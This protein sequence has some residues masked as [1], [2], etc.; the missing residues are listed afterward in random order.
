MVNLTFFKLYI[1]L[2]LLFVVSNLKSQIIINEV[3]PINHKS[4]LDDDH[5]NEDWIE[6]YNP[7][8][9][10][11]NLKGYK[12][13]DRNDF[14]KA[15]VFPDTIMPPKSFLTLFASDKNRN[16]DDKLV[17]ETSGSGLY[18]WIYPEGYSFAY[19]EYEGDFEA[20]VRINTFQNADFWA[21]AGIMVREKL[22]NN[23]KFIAFV[24]REYL[25]QPDI[26]CKYRDTNSQRMKR[27]DLY[28]A[29]E[30]DYPDIFLHLIRKGN[31]FTMNYTDLSGIVIREQ[32][33]VLDLP[34]KIYLGLS[35]NSKNIE[36]TAKIYFSDYFI[37]NIKVDYNN[38]KFF[39]IN[40][41][42]KGK[43][44]SNNTLHT[45]FK[46]GDEESL[47]LFNDKNKLL[48]YVGLP[49]L[50]ADNTFSRN[51]NENISINSK[52]GYA[53]ATPNTKNSKLFLG[54]T[55]NPIFQYDK[56]IFEDKMSVKIK[57]I[58][59]SKI[60]FN[61][62]SDEPDT[63]S[64]IYNFTNLNI[65]KTTV[66]RARAFKDNYLP[67]DIITQ[68]FI[69]DYKSKLPVISLV[70]KND[71]LYNINYGILTNINSNNEI[72]G[73]LEFFENFDNI[74]NQNIGIKLHGG[75][76][77]TSDQKSLRLYARSVYNIDTINNLMFFKNG[78]ENKLIKNLDRVVLRSGGQDYYST[79]VR[80]IFAHQ[81]AKKLENLDYL[82]FNY[83]NLFLNG[84]YYGLTNIIERFDDNFIIQYYN[85]EDE[86]LNMMGEY[87]KTI[88]GNGL[89]YKTHYDSVMSYNSQDL[90]Y[91]NKVKRNFN[92]FNFLDYIFLNTFISTNDWSGQN[93][94]TWN[95]KNSPINFQQYDLDVSLQLYNYYHSMNMFYTMK[96][97]VNNTNQFNLFFKVMENDSIKNYFILHALDKI[98]TSFSTDSMLA[99]LNPIVD[100]IKDEIPAHQAKFPES[101]PNWSNAI[102]SIRFFL[103]ERPELYRLHLAEFFELPYDLKTVKINFKKVKINLNT[104]TLDKSF[105]GKYFINQ[106][107]TLEVDYPN[108][109]KFLYWLV[110][111]E[112]YSTNPKIEV[113]VTNN[114]DIIPVFETKTTQLL[115]A[116]NVF[117][118]PNPNNGNITLDINN[119]LSKNN[120]EN[121][122]ENLLIEVYDS[123]Q[124][125]IT[126][127]K[128]DYKSY[129]KDKFKLNLTEISNKLITGVYYLNVIVGNEIIYTNKFIIN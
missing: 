108:D 86:D 61:I 47:Y 66:F 75:I 111:N 2:F 127:I 116:Y 24:A 90:D 122:K 74:I 39:E 113:F 128:L 36:K 19:Q 17:M 37:N 46:I 121:T 69:K 53:N 25:F 42:D 115:N 112:I 41:G 52:W 100:L 120:K 81:L 11:V 110:N 98:N 23:S 32:K 63:N 6:L 94:K 55:E 30:F 70:A 15:W 38:L 126:S 92:L 50:K 13:N 54:Y 9:N 78:I 49:K 102:D 26:F 96:A 43:I 48:D 56:V 35:G 28:T 103:Q 51:N 5:K 83:A 45:N 109:E 107:I 72:V 125:I 1:V 118:Y 87:T 91:L 12:I 59:N 117:S 8:D 68:S 71:D 129:E 18:Y 34:P 22:D 21:N 124:K 106:K 80:D 10:D 4:L 67:S 123:N 64:T 33:L 104:I 95:V 76:S 60:Y 97:N 58:E 101:V 7:T 57:E 3:C 29:R 77:R 40:T 99:V 119:I 93:H 65:D 27:I 14:K 73:N 31:E 88:K 114:L 16:I 79:K 105:E 84:E 44:Y 89:I 20:K 85:F 62:N 82:E